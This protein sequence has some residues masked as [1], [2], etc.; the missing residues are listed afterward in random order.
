M[1]SICALSL[2]L[3]TALLG[4]W[5]E[6][7]GPRKVAC[8][9]GVCWGSGLLLSGIGCSMHELPLMWVAGHMCLLLVS[10]CGVHAMS[11]LVC[12][13]TCAPCLRA[14]LNMH[15]LCVLFVG[16]GVWL[17]REWGVKLIV[18]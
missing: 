11:V 9:A 15:V 7:S 1:F 10:K 6:R 17:L 2:G 4:P 5:A 16:R 14:C 8:V 13:R 12:L 3:C 18:V